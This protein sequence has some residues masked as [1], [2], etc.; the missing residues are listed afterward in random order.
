MWVK[1]MKSVSESLRISFAPFAGAGPG[2]EHR[3]SAVKRGNLKR[4]PTPT[5]LLAP[6]LQAL[7]VLKARSKPKS[8]CEMDA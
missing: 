5:L 6:T 2:E 4:P 1:C 8:A 7:R 3:R